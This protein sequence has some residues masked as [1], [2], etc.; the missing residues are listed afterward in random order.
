MANHTASTVFVF[1]APFFQPMRQKKLFSVI[2]L[3]FCIHPSNFRD[4]TLEFVKKITEERSATEINSVALRV[5]EICAQMFFVMVRAFD[6]W[7]LTSMPF[8]SAY[9][10]KITIQQEAHS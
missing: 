7:L 3:K 9:T 6:P 2:S 10:T 1:R 8:L 4:E 5:P